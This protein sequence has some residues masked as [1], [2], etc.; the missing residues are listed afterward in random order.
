MVGARSLSAIET[1]PVNR[2]P[3]RTEVVQRS[4]DLLK[5][6]IGLEIRRDGRSLSSQSREDHLLSRKKASSPLSQASHCRWAW[7]NE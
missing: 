1:A 6:A 7:A 5:R 2:R 4:D 3:I